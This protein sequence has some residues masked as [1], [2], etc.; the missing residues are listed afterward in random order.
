[1]DPIAKFLKKLSPKQRQILLEKFLPKIRALDLS[2]LN[3]KALKGFPGM[4]RVRYSG[5]RVIFSKD[6][7]RNMGIIFALDSR[8]QVYRNLGN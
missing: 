5:F 1:M 8:K 2:G 7:E 4:Y 6:S 3:V